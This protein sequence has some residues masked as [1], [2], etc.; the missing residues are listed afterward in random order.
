M[1][2]M[3][4]QQ[5]RRESQ[6]QE[7]SLSHILWMR[8]ERLARQEH[9]LLDIVTIFEGDPNIWPLTCD[10]AIV[11]LIK[12]RR[13]AKQMRNYLQHLD[14]DTTMSLKPYSAITR[15]DM[16]CYQLMEVAIT[17]AMFQHISQTITQERV[18]LHLHIVE[19]F[20]AV[21]ASFYDSLEQMMIL[22]ERSAR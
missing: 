8:I 2:A 16:L 3:R 19:L 6:V 12:M 17:I 18:Q 7:H 9:R 21:L 15:L 11:H 1:V 10:A 13:I 5:Q 20:P 14:P 4:A 22:V